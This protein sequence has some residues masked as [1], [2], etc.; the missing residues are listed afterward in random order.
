MSRLTNALMGE[1]AYGRGSSQP[2]LDPSVGNGYFG[3]APSVGDFVSNQAYVRRNLIPVLLEAPRFFQLMPEPEKWVQTLKALIEIHCR[4]IEGLNAGLTVEWD[5]HP[6]GGGGEFQQEFTDVKRARSEPS[7]TFVEKYGRPIQT[8]IYNWITY[9]MMDPETKYALAGTLE[10]E[11]PEDMLA[12]WYTATV[13]FIEPD[14]TH[15]K[16]V[17]SWLTS[18]MAPKGTGEIIGKRDLTTASEVLNLTIEFTGISQYGLGTNVFAQ[19]ILD[20]INMTN[21]NPYLRQ[22]PITSRDADVATANAVTGYDK[23]VTDLGNSAVPGL[24]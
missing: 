1:R 23:S 7:F 10:G 22:S 3:W 11:R 12:D 20:E 5:E 16:V 24:R 19:S 21:S 14:P 9:G 18:N 8:F 2:M 6:V 15:T 4:T 13:L 17:Q